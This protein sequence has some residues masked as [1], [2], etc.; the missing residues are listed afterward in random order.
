MNSCH[1]IVLTFG[2]ILAC[3]STALGQGN[4]LISDVGTNSIKE[5]NGSTGAYMGTFAQG[6]GLSVPFGLAYGPDNNLYVS[7]LGNSKILEYNGSTGAFIGTFATLQSN[8]NAYPNQIAFGPD[9][10]LYVSSYSANAVL[11]YE[12][13]KSG[14]PGT[15]DGKF[16]TATGLS[17][18]T[19][20]AFHLDNNGS[21]TLYV[22]SSLNGQ[23]FQF[24][25]TNGSLVGGGPLIN[26]A[27]HLSGPAGLAFG[28]D[29]NIYQTSYTAAP[30][31]PNK[32]IVRYDQ[33]TGALLN[34]F[35]GSAVLGAP[36][37]VV[38]NSKLMY[39][40]DYKNNAVYQYNALTGA[41]KNGGLPFIT[42]AHLSDPTYMIF[43]PN[44]VSAVPSGSVVGAAVPEPTSLA[45][46]TLG[47][48]GLY[49]YHRRKQALAA[50]AMG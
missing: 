26:D 28:P 39:V 8:G 24:N 50:C 38:F 11:K 41:V 27:S 44:G 6:G 16:A 17:G 20:I 7:S 13:P 25:S 19:G 10:N 9:G 43:T 1:K 31:N 22:N 5:F 35:T 3:G 12:G 47:V 36:A 45:L 33:S 49:G 14:T 40:T 18:P 21:T 29:G 46:L 32:G 23:V 42:S 37:D 48:A 15:Y 34:I 2:W 4:I 30:S